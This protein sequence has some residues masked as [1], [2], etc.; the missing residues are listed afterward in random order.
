MYVVGTTN[1]Y[2]TAN[3]FIRHECPEDEQ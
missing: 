1:L 3:I 2:W